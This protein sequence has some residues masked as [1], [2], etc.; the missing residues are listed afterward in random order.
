[1]IDSEFVPAIPLSRN[2][3]KK[4]GLTDD[5][6][7]PR[8]WLKIRSRKEA[9]ELAALYAALDPES[10]PL[11]SDLFGAAYIITAWSLLLELYSDGPDP[12]EKGALSVAAESADVEPDAALI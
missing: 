7:D 4:L 9:R 10:M 11:S 2:A 6:Y 12:Y 1:M 8:G 3:R 5:H